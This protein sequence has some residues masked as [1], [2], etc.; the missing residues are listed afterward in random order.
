[1]LI[2]FLKGAKAKLAWRVRVH[3]PGMDTGA[4]RNVLGSFLGWV[5]TQLDWDERVV[6]R[7]FPE[8]RIPPNTANP[9]SIR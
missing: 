5:A 4:A 9:D 8:I 2:G 6:R 3:A 7:C 1:M